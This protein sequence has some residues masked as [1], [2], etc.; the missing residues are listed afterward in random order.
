MSDQGRKADSGSNPGDALRDIGKPLAEGVAK[1]PYLAALVLIVVI[2]AIVAIAFAPVA[3]ALLATIA[4]II[5]FVLALI[6]VAAIIYLFRAGLRSQKE[7][8]RRYAGGRIEVNGNTIDLAKGLTHSQKQ[9]I[10]RALEGAAGDVAD[11]LNVPLDLVRSNLFGVD[12][13][14]RMRMLPELVFQ[15]NREEELT[16]SMPAG[17]GSSGRCFQSGK[18]N[19]AILREGWGADVIEDAEL[20]KVHPDLQWI[21]SAP[22]FAGDDGLRPVWVL[23]VDGLQE[24]RGED[25]L[26]KTLTRLPYWSQAIS[27]IAAKDYHVKE[28]V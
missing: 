26:Q 23:N 1:N 5:F 18:P 10:L 14:N 15:M 17:Y 4:L 8:I 20:R 6:A 7:Q 16:I 2:G 28:E 9:H 22:I 12:D 19:I 27:L 25:A 3:T 24:K 21:I 13:Q 11:L